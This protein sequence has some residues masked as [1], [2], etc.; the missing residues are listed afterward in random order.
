MFERLGYYQF[1]AESEAAR[2]DYD[3]HYRGPH[4][5]AIPLTAPGDGAMFLR[6]GGV[7][8]VIWVAVALAISVFN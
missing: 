3:H 1:R 7:V 2:H 5:V 6:L 8:V 4:S